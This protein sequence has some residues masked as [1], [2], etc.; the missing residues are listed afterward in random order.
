MRL[1]GHDFSGHGA[2]WLRDRIHD[3]RGIG[4]NFLSPGFRIF[5]WERSQ[6]GAIRKRPERL[7]EKLH[8]IRNWLEL[9]QSELVRRLGIEHDCDRSTISKYERGTNEP[10]LLTL[11]KY[12][13]AAGVYLEDI[14]D[15]ELDLPTKLPGQTRRPKREYPPRRS[16][17]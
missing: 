16:R 17:R 7:P 4:D 5:G 3:R 12:A 11:L 13:R 1:T 9:S 8:H 2:K 6:M 10:T 14:V 15:D